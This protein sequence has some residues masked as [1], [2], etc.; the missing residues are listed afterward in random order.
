MQCKDRV[1]D[2]SDVAIVHKFQDSQQKLE[3]KN[4]LSLRA[5]RGT[6]ALEISDFETP[7]L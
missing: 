4:K 3:G 6:T 7:E 2:C 1:K 5:L